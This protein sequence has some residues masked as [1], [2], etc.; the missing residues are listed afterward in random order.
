LEK[1]EDGESS[2]KDT[3]KNKIKNTPK[4]ENNPEK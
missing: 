4:K 1:L 3:E 2:G